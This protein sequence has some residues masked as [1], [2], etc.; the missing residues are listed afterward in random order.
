MAENI[1]KLYRSG[2]NRMFF[3]VCGGLGEYLHTDPSVIRV[4]AVILCVLS[5]GA[6]L[7]G[8]IAMVFIVPEQDTEK[9]S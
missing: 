1:K 4:L 6:G 5:A 7:I 8:Y 9:L 3:G 2:I